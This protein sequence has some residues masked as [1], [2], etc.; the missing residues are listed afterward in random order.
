MPNI[1]LTKRCN[2]SCPYCF[3]N[4]FVNRPSEGDMSLPVF[5]EI[6][7]FLLRDGSVNKMGL[8][9]GEPTCHEQFGDILS[10]LSEEE[11]LEQV[12]LYTN[13]IRLGEYLPQLKGKKFCFLI[14]CNEPERMGKYWDTLLETLEQ[15]RDGDW[16][17]RV[18]LGIN[19]YKPELD[20]TYMLELVDRFAPETLRVSVS[21][22]NREDDTYEPFSYFEA[23]KPHIFDFFHQLEQRGVIPFF[24]CNVFPPCLIS[25]GEVRQ[26]DRWGAR[27]PF[28]QLKNHASGCKPVID[29]MD[30]MTAVRCFGLSA[31]T[32]V[33]I[34]E[35][36]SFT[37]LMY[38]Y[39]RQVD[40][41]AVN[42]YHSGKCAACYYHK[43][44][45]CSG[46]CLVYKIDRM[47]ENRKLV[48]ERNGA[49]KLRGPDHQLC[50]TEV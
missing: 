26:F 40:A 41:Y 28:L 30:D 50:W 21:V 19:F 32:K 8:I 7:A 31:Y 43:T 12:T 9:G 18:T 46:G 35:F 48:E 47:L 29:I 15:L 13:G 44:M 4:D 14:N 24:D 10:L 11:R 38:Y 37:D 36:S 6:L 25:D 27:N 22:P 42:T 39:L 1:M 17:G 3:A 45:R 16:K 34:Y 33:S 23:M 5:R 20:Y 2:L 49:Y